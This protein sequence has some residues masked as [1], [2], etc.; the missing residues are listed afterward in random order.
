[1]TLYLK[2]SVGRTSYLIA[3]ARV[4]DV[5]PA[6]ATAEAGSIDCRTLFGEPAAAPGCRLVAEPDTGDPVTLIVDRIDGL[7]ELDDAAFRPLP[8]IGRCGAAIEAVSVPVAGE[9]PALRLCVGPAL[10]VD[11]P[12]REQIG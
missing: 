3:A 6:E 4:T 7:V 12:A 1:V 2:A 5:A 11:A 8:P 9:A 10:F